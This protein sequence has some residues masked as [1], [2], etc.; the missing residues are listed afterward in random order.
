MKTHGKA[1]VLGCG[2]SGAAAAQLL[3]S[4]GT[5]VI[6][7]DGGAGDE[8]I[9][10]ADGLRHSGM[11][12]VTDCRDLPP[13]DYD[14]CVAS[15]GVSLSSPLLQQARARKLPVLSELELGW[16]RCRCPVVAVTG[17]NGKSTAVKWIAESLQAGGLR[18]EPAGNYGPPV[19]KIVLEQ[20]DLDWLVLE[21]S[22]FQLETV[23]E[24]RAEVGIL[25]N[26]HPNHLD[27]HGDMQTYRMLKAKLFAQSKGSDA[28][29][30]HQPLLEEARRLSGR[31]GRWI[32]FG[33][34][35]GA[36][37]LYKNGIVTAGGKQVLDL[38]GTI[39]AN[40]V[41]GQAGAAV[42]AALVSCGLDSSCVARAASTFKPLPHRMQ[43]VGEFGGVRF[44]NDSKATNLAAMAAALR[45]IPSKIRLIAGGLGK[46]KDY[47][48]VKELLAKKVQ[49]VYLIGRTSK[50]MASAWS[51]AVPCFLCETL[52]IAVRRATDDAKEGDVILLSPAC[53]S[54]DQFRNFEERGDRFIRLVE[55]RVRGG[56]E[57]EMKSAPPAG[58]V[59]DLL[60]GVSGR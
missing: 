31:K 11:E 25:L 36:D 19:S 45:M 51:D 53:A 16:S 40:D 21:V 24:F 12:G 2:G 28:C 34:S 41:L 44:I 30:V 6:V 39:F 32:S 54:F 23:S 56:I 18:A 29:I 13:G 1:L 20:K 14:V 52:E 57:R 10:R 7:L 38:Q 15:P 33:N 26:I 27:R 42:A 5:H 50:E 35:A 22:T 58:A 59:G 55:D 37:Y 43:P 3:H 60:K 46:E 8:G 17:S 4:E 9:A 49:G 48:F 47:S